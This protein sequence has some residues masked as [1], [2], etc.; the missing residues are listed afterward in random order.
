MARPKTRGMERGVSPQRHVETALR[1]WLGSHHGVIGSKEA[2]R[3]GATPANIQSKVRRGEWARMHRGVYRDTAV[4]TSPCQDL[5]AACVAT[6]GFAVVSHVS[7]AWVWGLLR[8]APATPELTVLRGTRDLHARTGLTIHRS[9]DL[10]PDRAVQRNAI[11]VTNPMRTL[12]DT[13]GVVLP[14]QLAEAVD[15]AVAAKLVAITGLEA[16]IRQLSRRGR[17][18]VGVLRRH[19]L[20]RGFVG[21]P[22]PSVLEARTHRLIGGTGLPEPSVELKVG[23]E[24]ELRLDIAWAA[25]LFAVEVDGYAYH[26]SPEHL[27]RDQARRNGLERAGWTVL[28]YTWL[29]VLREPARVAREITTT[30]RR[31]SASR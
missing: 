31:L 16:E 3:L 4:P 24:G 17:P 14:H 1:Q 28:V 9:G 27:R 8:Q 22:A 26:F 12:V 29:D 23:D 7:A 18:G 30:H 5:R 2:L 6:A 13:A 20:D 19:L 15:N 21:A 11:L 25:I 10:A